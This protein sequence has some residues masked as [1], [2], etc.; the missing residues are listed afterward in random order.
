MSRPSP[1]QDYCH[2]K[3]EPSPP[4]VEKGLS[5]LAQGLY[6]H[7]YHAFDIAHLRN[8]EPARPCRSDPSKYEPVH[9]W[10]D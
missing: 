7:G 10:P 4:W 8:V 3:Q 2:L 9:P 6:L 1:T 5:Q